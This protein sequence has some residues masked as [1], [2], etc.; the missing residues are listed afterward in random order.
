MDTVESSNRRRYRKCCPVR[1]GDRLGRRWRSQSLSH[2][3]T[4]PRSA[5]TIY[6]SPARIVCKS[7][8]AAADGRWLQ[9]G[10]GR[11]RVI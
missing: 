2:Q 5:L 10:Y 11:F 4:I 8:C 7:R 1:E 6:G 3:I 9:Y